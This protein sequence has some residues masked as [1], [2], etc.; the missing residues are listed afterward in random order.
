MEL[1][2]FLNFLD[3][4]AWGPRSLLNFQDRE[5]WRPGAILASAITAQ[6]PAGTGTAFMFFLFQDMRNKIFRIAV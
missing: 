4:E 5:A 3:K 1:G 6:G 2:S